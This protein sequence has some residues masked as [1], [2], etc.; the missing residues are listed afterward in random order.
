VGC[1]RTAPQL[2]L[3]RVVR[4][5]DGALRTGRGLEGRGAWLCA[6]DPVACLDLATRRR[7][8]ARAFR[9]AVEPPA[10][11]ELRHR[12]QTGSE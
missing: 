9:A 8:W 7:A 10:V 5:A 12:L 4:T 6:A 3:V 1:R 11:A 2:A